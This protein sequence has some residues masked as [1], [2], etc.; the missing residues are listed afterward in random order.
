MAKIDPH[1]QTWKAIQGFIESER[2]TAIQRLIADDK[3][4]QQRGAINLLEQLEKLTEDDPI[5]MKTDTYN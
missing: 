2:K 4:E 3:S 5:V 1:S